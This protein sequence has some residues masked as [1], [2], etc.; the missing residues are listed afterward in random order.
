MQSLDRGKQYYLPFTV[1]VGLY[2]YRA[3]MTDMSLN[4]LDFLLPLKKTQLVVA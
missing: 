1:V 4:V 3:H 2:T